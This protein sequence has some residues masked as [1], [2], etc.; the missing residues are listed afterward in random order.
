MH[1]RS[2]S[3]HQQNSRDI[4]KYAYLAGRGREAAARALEESLS[5]SEHDVCDSGEEKETGLDWM[6]VGGVGK[7]REVLRILNV[8]ASSAGRRSY[9]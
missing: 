9:G 3:P 8:S 6:E 2:Q 1:R 4:R 5:G 7:L